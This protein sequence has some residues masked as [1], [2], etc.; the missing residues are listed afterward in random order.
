MYIKLS[1]KD[2]L[3]VVPQ[4]A[5]GIITVLDKQPEIFEALP[6]DILANKVVNMQSVRNAEQ[7]HET[8]NAREERPFNDEETLSYDYYV[9]CQSMS[10]I[11]IEKAIKLFL[12]SYQ[13]KQIST[14]L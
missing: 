9:D 6:A 10:R 1:F 13:N 14:N 3:W 8:N 7:Q 12:D 11:A 5:G 2:V 4:C